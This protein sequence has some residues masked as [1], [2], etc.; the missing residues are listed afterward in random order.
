MLANCNFVRLRGPILVK[1]GE[2]PGASAFAVL[3]RVYMVKA[4][5]A[6]AAAA[7]RAGVFMGPRGL[8]NGFR[9][10]LEGPFMAVEAREGKVVGIKYRV[11]RESLS[12]SR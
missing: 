3:L 4:P 2:P 12:H 9:P 8:V 7:T 11:N 10:A 6:T 5:T 1:G